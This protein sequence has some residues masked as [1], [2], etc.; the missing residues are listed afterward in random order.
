MTTAIMETS[1]VVF[2]LDHYGREGRWPAWFERRRAAGRLVIPRAVEKEFKKLQRANRKGSGKHPDL[3]WM[4]RLKGADKSWIYDLYQDPGIDQ[5]ILSSVEGMHREALNAPEGPA[6]TKWLAVKKKYLL[7]NMGADAGA[8]AAAAKKRALIH[9][10]DAAR[11]DRVIA[12]QAVS[13]ARTAGGGCVLV[14]RDADFTA[15]AGRL[16]EISGC[17]MRVVRP[18]QM[19]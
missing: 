19:R 18:E 4:A 8:D 2:V 7:K 12:A 9:L 6:A 16:E 1:A 11:A 10:R 17:G 13:I 3:L 14:A 15:F 5:E